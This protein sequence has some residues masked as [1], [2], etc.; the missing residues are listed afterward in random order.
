MRTLVPISS[1]LFIR[2]HAVQ[3]E[4]ASW[5]VKSPFPLQ[6]TS[7]ITKCAK[8]SD[9]RTLYAQLKHVHVVMS[10]KIRIRSQKRVKVNDRCDR[11]PIRDYI[12]SRLGGGPRITDEC[13]ACLLDVELTLQLWP[14]VLP[15]IQ[16]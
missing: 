8:N 5:Y 16:T 10:V 7:I 2:A 1:G 13:Q 4:R 11:I 6:G 15:Q 12:A 14:C 9:D 3:C